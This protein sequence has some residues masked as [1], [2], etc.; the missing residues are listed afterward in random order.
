MEHGKQ[1]LMA[2]F[3]LDSPRTLKTSF[4]VLTEPRFFPPVSNLVACTRNLTQ[5]SKS[6]GNPRF[7]LGL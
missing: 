7:S 3:L 6:F 4:D 2:G 5:P 1:A